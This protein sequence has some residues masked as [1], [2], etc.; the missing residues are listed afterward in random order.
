MTN[1]RTVQGDQNLRKKDES[2][3]RIIISKISAIMRN[4]GAVI[5][6]FACMQNNKWRD[7]M[8]YRLAYSKNNFK[9]YEFVKHSI[10][11]ISL[12]IKASSN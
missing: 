7:V 11:G 6:P 2:K 8:F 5:A 9:L 10:L 12:K 1:G 4:A 3:Y